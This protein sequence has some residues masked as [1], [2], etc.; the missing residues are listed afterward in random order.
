V[1]KQRPKPGA[2]IRLA[3]P[4]GRFAFGRVY[5]DATVC[6]Y[7]DAGFDPDSPPIGSRDF[8][9]CTGVSDDAVKGWTVC[10]L[11][12]FQPDE[13]DG[14]PPPTSVRDPITGRFKIYYRG[15]MREADEAEAATLEPAAVWDEHHL[16][17]RLADLLSESP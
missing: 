9:F 2:V 14:W 5:R 4:D 11:D 8:L 3:L 17:G 12:P 10:G 6:W 1:T 16:V 15:A 7:G 13:D